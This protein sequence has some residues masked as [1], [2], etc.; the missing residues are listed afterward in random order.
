MKKVIITLSVLIVTLSAN[1]SNSLDITITDMKEAIYKLIKDVSYLKKTSNPIAKQKV[2][3][4]SS[5]NKIILEQKAILK[6]LEALENTIGRKGS[7]GN[8]KIGIP[9]KY[10]KRIQSYVQDNLDLLD[11]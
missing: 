9:S 5:I 2:I 1:S 11:N 8:K 4:Q 7:A 6:R 10:D 3:T